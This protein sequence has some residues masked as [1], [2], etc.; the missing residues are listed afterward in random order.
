V[1]ERDSLNDD[2]FSQKA[3]ISALKGLSV[4]KKICD[5]VD[6]GTCMRDAFTTWSDGIEEEDIETE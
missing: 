2:I 5:G 3:K 1:P 4:R 6:S